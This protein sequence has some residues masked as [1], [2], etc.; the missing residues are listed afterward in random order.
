[1]RN[2]PRAFQ[3]REKEDKTI[4][5]AMV[6]HAPSFFV[7]LFVFVVVI[8]LVLLKFSKY[9]SNTYCV[10]SSIL[11]SISSNTMIKNT[12]NYLNYIRYKFYWGKMRDKQFTEKDN[13]R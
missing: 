6:L 10:V 2:L 7:C 5:E 12:E 4:S 3:N 9:L 1:M 13:F 8:V 11:S